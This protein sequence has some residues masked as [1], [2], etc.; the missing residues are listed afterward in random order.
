MKTLGRIMV[1]LLLI[2]LIGLVRDTISAEPLVKSLPAPVLI[3]KSPA[4]SIQ[5]KGS[6]GNDETPGEW[7]A[8]DIPANL[9]ADAPVLLFVPGLNNAAQIFWE[10]NDMYQTAYDAGYQT[11]FLQLHDAGGESAD[12]WEN[13]QLLAEKIEEIAA[14]FSNKPI[15]VIA[16]SKGGVDTHT[17]ITYYGAG[18][19]V[20]NVIT[21]SSPHHGSQL[22]DLAN[23]SWAGWLAN[24][25]GA[26]GDGTTAMETGNMAHFRSITDVEPTASMH[27]Y[28]TIGGTNWGSMFSS[29][30]FGGMYLNSY[31]DNDGV[32]T[33]NSSLLPV[34]QLL[35]IGNWNHTTVRSGATFSIFESMIMDNNL[36]HFNQYHPIYEEAIPK[37]TSPNQWMTGGVLEIGKEKSI[38]LTLD[39]TINKADIQLLTAEPLSRIELVD[40]SGKITSITP[41]TTENNEGYFINSISHHFTLKDLQPGKWQLRLETSKDNAYLFIADYDAETLVS[42]SADA[43]TNKS[44]IQQAIT[45]DKTKVKPETIKTTY[46][47][48]ESGADPDD[49]T[50][51]ESKGN[52]TQTVPLQKKNQSYVITVEVEGTTIEGN[53]FKRTYVNSV[54]RSE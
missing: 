51:Y 8:G 42:V 3:E 37:E 39:E 29:T 34:G 22:A 35:E 44:Q 16:Y 25:I 20:E 11:A 13:G 48:K 2:L 23:S 52:T 21:L 32:V 49:V 19:Y 30:W 9:I 5:G 27:D 33:T 40:P 45:V 15:T 6:N 14:H 54:Y 46:Y 10:D 38:A 41:K 7:Y 1:S 26:Q 31:G 36:N 18:P 47:V 4:Y 53:A 12:M 28:Y 17:A 50:T 24:L 43:F